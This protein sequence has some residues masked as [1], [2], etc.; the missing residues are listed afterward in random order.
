MKIMSGIREMLN[1]DGK[2]SSKRVIAMIM[3]VTL[4]VV[5]V[6]YPDKQDLIN[7]I[8]AFILGLVVSSV[9]NKHKA[10]NKG[11]ETLPRDSSTS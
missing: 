9:A 1:E 11:N 3:T 6:A 5:V 10:F 7:S 4:V 8:M 2:I